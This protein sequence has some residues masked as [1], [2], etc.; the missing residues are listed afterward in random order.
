MTSSIR[1]SITAASVADSIACVFDLQRFDD[2][3]GVHVDGVA[4]VGVE[5]GTELAAIVLR[6][7]FD[8]GVDGVEPSVLGQ[9]SRDDLERVGEGLDCELFAAAD[10]VSVVA[11]RERDVDLGCAAAGEHLAVFER[12]SDD[13]E[14]VLDGAV[15]L[16]DD[17]LGA[18][19]EDQRDSLCVL[20]IFDE[21][22]LVAGDLLLSNA[23]GGTEVVLGQVVDARDRRCAGRA[24]ATAAWSL[25]LTR[26]TAMMPS[27]AR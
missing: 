15:D 12:R 27:C 7:E 3:L 16:V 17:V 21:D 26:R 25:D 10:G 22:A 24:G 4:S 19:A 13:A 1:S 6:T 20:D 2:A 5:P 11:Q 23:T 9:R 18:T 14:G 8:E